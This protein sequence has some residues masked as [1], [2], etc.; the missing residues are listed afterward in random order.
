MTE[1]AG[2]RLRETMARLSLEELQEIAAG[3][4]EDFTAEARIAARAELEDREARGATSVPPEPPPLPARESGA[5]SLVPLWRR[6]VASLLAFAGAV[7][8]QTAVLGLTEAWTSP[9][10]SALL[11]L[12][13][14]A[15]VGGS[16]VAY[17]GLRLWPPSAR[18]VVVVFAWGGIRALQQMVDLFRAES[19]DWRL[20]VASG[21]GG[22]VCLLVAAAVEVRFRTSKMRQGRA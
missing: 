17:L 4:A 1:A 20:G 14:C 19:A 16:L 5:P 3:S 6:A 15:L 12:L 22:L 18:V 9:P 7:P 8:A 2:S 13:A 11:L 10:E 21:A